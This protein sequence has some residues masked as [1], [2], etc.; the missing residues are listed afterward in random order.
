MLRC[1]RVRVQQ[2]RCN[3]QGVLAVEV[4]E[5]TLQRQEAKKIEVL[6]YASRVQRHQRLDYFFVLEASRDM[7]RQIRPMLSKTV[8]ASGE[9]VTSRAATAVSVHHCQVKR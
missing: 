8:T 2:R 7:Q 9:A 4:E 5:G 6:L 1:L 3:L